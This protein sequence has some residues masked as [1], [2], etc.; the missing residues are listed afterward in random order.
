MSDAGRDR[1][2]AI[3]DVG[4]LGSALLGAGR[5]TRERVPLAAKHRRWSGLGML[6]LARRW[7]LRGK[8]APADFV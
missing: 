5:G 8:L 3:A 4:C 6:G 7:R 1:R 2:R